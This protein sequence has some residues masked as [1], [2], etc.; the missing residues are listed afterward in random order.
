MPV[1]ARIALFEDVWKRPLREIAAE[2]GVSDV[3]LR[4]ICD[5][6]DIP[7]PG[8][9]Y[10]AQ[11]RAGRS[12]PRPRLRPVKDPRLEEVHVVGGPPLPLAVVDA[13]RKA[14]EPA[15]KASEEPRPALSRP[16][17]V[18]PAMAS[19][20]PTMADPT[21][22]TTE[23][24]PSPPPAEPAPVQVRAQ[25]VRTQ[26]ALAKARVDTH[27]FVTVAGD[28]VVPM[29]IGP[30]SGHAAVEFLSALLGAAEARD[31]SLQLSDKVAALKIEDEA[32]SFR[33][34]E[35]ADK[36]A[37]MPT[38]QELKRKAERDRSGGDHQTWPTWDLSPSGRLSLVIDENSYSGLRRTFLQRK[39][40][41]LSASLETIIA[42]FA[43]HAAL[44]AER[45][46]EE[47]ARAR[48]AALAQARRERPEAFGRR[49]VRRREFVDLVHARLAER[50]KLAAVLTHVQES[51]DGEVRP[52]ADLEAW[53][54]RRL[55][56]LD[57]V[58]SPEVLEVSARHS[59][60][61]FAEPPRREAASR[62]YAP[63]VELELW[64]RD[65]TE[66]VW[67]ATSELDW[68]IARGL[69]ADPRE[70]GAA[71]SNPASDSYG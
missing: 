40:Q 36:T 12:F 16:R 44:K 38:A 35:R 23:S 63:K 59:E 3:G 62:W 25:F 61:D 70:A 26:K 56:A 18:K 45:R 55:G 20:G 19:A 33:L 27:G 9:G 2:L 37:H 47:E 43:G 5:R 69:A 21:P 52:L 34:E 51:A 30:A 31:W 15:P 68:A 50:A 41:P 42:G 64:L 66:P 4:K 53:L 24:A 65:P 29:K 54:Q 7:T 13:M 22:P 57:V 71:E 8:R 39:D 67:R 46:R 17:R 6:H 14:R 1:L 10:W 49:E 32:L 58:L 60:V 11:V 28:G 48:A